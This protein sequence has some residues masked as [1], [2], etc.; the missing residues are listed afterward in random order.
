VIKYLFLLLVLALV[1]YGLGAKRSR[2]RDGDE[3][4]RPKA[5]PPAPPQSM[6]ACAQCGV[7]LPAQDALPGR[8]GQFC[9]AGHRAA[10]EARHPPA[11]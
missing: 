7:H 5:P 1:F 3:A 8:G 2:P 4:A 11:E 6:V 10:F 9:S